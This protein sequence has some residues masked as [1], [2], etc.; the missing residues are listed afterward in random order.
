MSSITSSSSAADIPT[1]VRVAS[2]DLQGLVVAPGVGAFLGI[3]Y[4]AAPVGPL[5][6]AD[7][8]P[9]PRWD[10]VRDATIAGPAPIQG[11]P[12]P[13]RFLADLS[14]PVQAEDC[15]NVSVWTPAVD[16]AAKLPV[17]VWFYG[18]AFVAGSNS[19]PAYDGARLDA[20]R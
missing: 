14:S 19:V 6:F 15:L 18:G 1:R 20:F 3:P 4:A 13:G 11:A 17:M 10:G 9:A 2:G 5:R 7:P 8:A 16:P 12:S